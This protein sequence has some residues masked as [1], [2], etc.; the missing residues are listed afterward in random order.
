MRL[1]WRN[2]QSALRTVMLI[3]Y[4][5][6]VRLA[7]STESS[8]CLQCGWVQ[9]DKI[10]SWHCEQQCAYDVRLANSTEICLTREIIPD[11][12]ERCDWEVDKIC[13]RHCGRCWLHTMS[14]YSNSTE[15]SDSRDN[16]D[17]LRTQNVPMRL[18]S[19]GRNQQ[20]ANRRNSKHVCT[21]TVERQTILRP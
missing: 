16:P 2:L 7:I 9:S 5:V 1:G 6:Q 3:A 18:H 11:K 20:L 4:D 21:E 12:S 13:N 8:K 14:G 15:M 19:M 10:C 17:K